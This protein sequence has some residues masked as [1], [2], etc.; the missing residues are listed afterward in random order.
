MKMLIAGKW[1][2]GDG[3]I[4]VLNPFD[5]SVIDTVP[6]ASPA[7]A[8][9]AVRSAQR[10]FEIM[11]K[12]PA[13]ERSAILSRTAE[14]LVEHNEE[15]G[16]LLAQEVGKTLAEGCTEA[17]RA[18]ETFTLAA[19]EAKRI[20]GETVPY[21]AAAH[22]TNKMGFYIRVP[23]G[24]VCAITP[25]NFPLNL[26][27]HKVGPAI[28]A[29]CS[30]I[31]KPASVTP[32][33]D[34]RMGELLLEAGLPPDAINI[35]TG[36]GETVGEALVADERIRKVSFTGSAEVGKRIMRTAGLKKCTMELGSNSAVV[37]MDDADLSAAADRIKVGGYAVAGQVCI[38]T[39][40]VLVRDGVF[41]DFMGEQLPR[42]Q[43]LAAGDQ[44]AEATDV[45]PMITRD[46]AAET[47]GHIREAVDAGAKLL[48]GGDR[49]GAVVQ[50][51][52]LLDVPRESFLGCSE[53]F[54]PLICVNRVSDI[55]EAI[56]FV[57][58]SPYGL[59]AGI[60]TQDISNAF[61]FIREAEVGGV[62]VN[63]VPTFR[64][65]GMPYGGVKDSGLGREGPRYAIEDMT[66]I[67]VVAFN[68]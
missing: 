4:E 7:Q 65:D 45:G 21:D 33:A 53:A 22:G 56:R 9:D 12:M 64:V 54:A 8:D 15:L 67:R 11:R 30:L 42:V 68:L 5:D 62:M 58:D 10:G 23:I 51:A 18:A 46:I 26:A 25:F 3:H 61:T 36:S 50:P 1:V 37:I 24:I 35:V 6:K 29:G 59:Q 39:Q 41:D 13:C 47:E 38:S 60:Y 16:R 40:R 32:L 48:C 66:E 31:L 2:E 34:L 63:E 27:A 14:L 20:H 17:S 55:D 52:V 49:D 19:E 57:N 28:A 44:L 43:G